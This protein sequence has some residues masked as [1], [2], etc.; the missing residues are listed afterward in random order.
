VRGGAID[1]EVYLDGGRIATIGSL[2]EGRFARVALLVNPPTFNVRLASNGARFSQLDSY[3]L[4]TKTAQRR[5]SSDTSAVVY[6]V[7]P[8]GRVRNHT[9]QWDHVT[10]V[11]F[12]PVL[13]VSALTM[14]P[15]N[16]AEAEVPVPIQI[17]Q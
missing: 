8:V 9:L 4:P 12:Y 2:P 3:Q 14:P 17:S 5:Y 6:V 13:P 10:Y 1:Y 16:A 15:S 11:R 7:S